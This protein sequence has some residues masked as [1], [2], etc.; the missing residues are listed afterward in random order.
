MRHQDNTGK[1]IAFILRHHPESIGMKLD[2]HGWART[3]DLIAGIA[4]SRPF[5]MQMLEEIV[6]TDSKQR[7]SF[8]E[9]KTLIRAN[10]GHSIRVDVELEQKT[11]SDVL[12]HGTGEKYVES[13]NK[14]GLI[15]KSRL[16]VH[17]SKDYETAKIVGSRHEKSV[18]YQMNAG[19]IGA[20][21]YLFY[22]SVNGV[23]LIKEVSVQYMNI[24]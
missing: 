23:W 10:Q 7:Y 8:N 24:L 18:V 22:L 19:K 16:Y 5:D 11:P 2:E 21:G 6:R 15:P 1:F 9:D 14:I 20:D 4:K 12:W 17:L 3:E 13:I